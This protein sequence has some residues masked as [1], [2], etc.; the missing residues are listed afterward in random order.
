VRSRGG[1]AVN[2][3]PPLLPRPIRIR[4]GVGQFS[5]AT[6][7]PIVLAP[8]ADHHTHLAARALRDAIEQKTG[9]RLPIEGHLRRSDLGPQIAL[10]HGGGTEGRAA[11]AYRL[12]IRPD[13]V[14]IRAPGP[15]GLRYAVETL[16]Q[17]IGARGPIPGCSIELTRHCSHCALKPQV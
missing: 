3:I 12:E 9:L 13:T 16:I 17:L 10:G 8:G 4:A 15:A 6:I 5:F 14:E 11:Q 1:D 7:I 2:E